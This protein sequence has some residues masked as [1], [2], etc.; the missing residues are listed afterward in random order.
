MPSRRTSRQFPGGYKGLA[1]TFAVSSLNS[2]VFPGPM[3]KK[4]RI[5]LCR[6]A[7]GPGHL[8]RPVFERERV[9]SR[10]MLRAAHLDDPQATLYE[11]VGRRMHLE[12]KDPVG[13]VRLFRRRAADSKVERFLRNQERQRAEV[14]QP[15]EEEVEFGPTILHLRHRLEYVERVDDQDR[16][17]I[18]LHHVLAV[19]LEQLEPSAA[20][21][22]VAQVL[23]D[24]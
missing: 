21:L 20:A 14:P 15:L 19:H 1:G 7:D 10:I 24:V 6:P 9:V 12:G 18:G 16:N 8:E 4:R 17:R 5:T 3:P 23:A 11:Q 22:E 13:E 2:Q